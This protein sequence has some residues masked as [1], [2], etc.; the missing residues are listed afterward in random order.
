[1][2]AGERTGWKRIK[3]SINSLGKDLKRKKK[4][5]KEQ[6]ERLQ[7]TRRRSLS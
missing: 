4:D 1:M 5:F 6:Q 3:K 2:P 7:R